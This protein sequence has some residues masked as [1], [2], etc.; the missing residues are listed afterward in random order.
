[1]RVFPL[2]SLYISFQDFLCYNPIAFVMKRIYRMR[3]HRRTQILVFER[4]MLICLDD[5]VPNTADLRCNELGG[6]SNSFKI[7]NFI[8]K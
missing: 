2:P 8:L 4:S 1:M 7:T 3:D 5:D 6:V